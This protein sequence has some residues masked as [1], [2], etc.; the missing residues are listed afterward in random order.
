[1]HTAVIAC[2]VAVLFLAA[3]ARVEYTIQPFGEDSEMKLPYGSAIDA[4]RNRYYVT[5]CPGNAI[6]VF[7]LD[8]EMIAKWGGVA[9]KEPGQFSHPTGL[10]VDRNGDVYVADYSNHRVQKLDPDGRPLKVLGR[11]GTGPG[12]FKL[13]YDV[14]V[15]EK[16]YIVVVDYGNHRIQ[17]FAPTGRI[18]SV[19]GRKG[20]AP[21]EFLGPLYVTIHAGLIYVSD[22]D[23][24]RIQVFTRR[25]RLVRQWSTHARVYGIAI[26]GRTFYAA[27]ASENRILRYTLD[28]RPRGEIA[29]TLMRGPKVLTAH[30]SMQ[31]LYVGNVTPPLLVRYSF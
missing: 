31:M 27:L 20:S 24:H 28:G 30:P 7:T 15:D 23:N 18:V 26:A 2:G 3:C 17:R 29:D 12:E 8:G 25:G 14:A 6:F 10:A 21:R 11:M 9:G 16:G 13:P 5:D 4:A 22:S 19:W 1:M